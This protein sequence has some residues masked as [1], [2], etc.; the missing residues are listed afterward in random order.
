MVIGKPHYLMNCSHY[1][2]SV[3]PIFKL[4]INNEAGTRQKTL[5]RRCKIGSITALS[6]RINFLAIAASLLQRLT[7]ATEA[8][9]HNGGSCFVVLI[10]ALL[11]DRKFE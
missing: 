5:C 3:H 6:M 11:Y 2:T 9:V 4:H 8:L 7:P 1:I 10:A